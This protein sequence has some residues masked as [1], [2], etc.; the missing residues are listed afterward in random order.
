M[1][2]VL[3]RKI[4]VPETL[5]GSCNF[6]LEM[7]VLS[8]RPFGKIFFAMMTL[9]FFHVV[10]S[11]KTIIAIRIGI[12]PPFI[13]F[14]LVAPKRYELDLSNGILN[15]DFGQGGAKISKLEVKKM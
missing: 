10:N 9:P 12:Q 4:A 14:R 11:V 13:T 7:K 15:I 3:V 6:K 1:D 2:G 8:F 5:F